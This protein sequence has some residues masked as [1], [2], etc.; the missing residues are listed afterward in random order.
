MKTSHKL[1]TIYHPTEGDR[2]KF[3][4]EVRKRFDS[5]S[6]MATKIVENPEK[7][8]NPALNE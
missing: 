3:Q 2:K 5:L 6:D 1:S 8:F 4:R 7:V